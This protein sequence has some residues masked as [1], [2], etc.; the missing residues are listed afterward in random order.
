MRIHY[1]RIRK[2]NPTLLNRVFILT[3]RVFV[4]DGFTRGHTLISLQKVI[5]S[6]TKSHKAIKRKNLYNLT[7][8]L[9]RESYTPIFERCHFQ[10]QQSEPKGHNRLPLAS[11]LPKTNSSSVYYKPILCFLPLSSR[12]V[13]RPTLTRNPF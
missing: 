9:G 7:I 10:K 3:S 12:H 8:K 5:S 6:N 4:H 1:T 2:I 11:D 13:Q